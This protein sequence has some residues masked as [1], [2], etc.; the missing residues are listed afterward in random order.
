M[1]VTGVESYIGLITKWST[2]VV[3]C[4]VLMVLYRLRWL[5]YPLQ[6]IQWSLMQ[7]YQIREQVLGLSRKPMET[8]VFWTTGAQKVAVL[9]QKLA[10]AAVD[11]NELN[12]LRH[13]VE[14]LSK[15]T[16]LHLA[17]DGGKKI[18]AQV[19][20]RD[21]T[22]V[23]VKAGGNDGVER[24][25]YALDETGVAVGRIVRVNPY[26]STVELP[27]AVHSRVG[28]KVQGRE[29]K[30]VLVGDGTRA[31]LTEVLQSETL[32]PEDV[33]ITLGS[34]G[35]FPAGLVVGTVGEIQSRAADA[36]QQASVELLGNPE[37][38]VI[39]RDS[40]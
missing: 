19:I 25:M 22:E 10:Q 29:S 5:D 38:M 34:E 24:G 4:L 33:I 30:G 17:G 40:I 20:E 3:G 18:A 9:E 27:N 36:M 26:Y 21:K 8:I 15:A 13:E 12:R 32:V 31:V 28:V 39:L 23:K 37:N 14:A 1:G 11:T 16:G 7:T 2:F 35:L 6:P